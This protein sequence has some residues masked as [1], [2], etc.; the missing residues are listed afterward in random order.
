MKLGR[1]ERRMRIKNKRRMVG[2]K[3]RRTQE[4]MLLRSRTRR[5]K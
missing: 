2:R 4:M 1:K 3:K 5:R